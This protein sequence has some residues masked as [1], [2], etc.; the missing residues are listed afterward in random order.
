MLFQHYMYGYVPP[1]PK[2]VRA[3][4]LLEEGRHLAGMATRKRIALR[5]GPRHETVLVL[6]LVVPNRRAGRVPCLFGLDLAE[7]DYAPAS[8]ERGFA[9]ATFL[10]DEAAPDAPDFS[11]GAWSLFHRPGQARRGPHE[12]GALAV[13]AWGLGIAADHLAAEE[14]IDPARLA[15]V[16]HSRKAKA[17]ILAGALYESIGMVI[18][19]QSGT[20]GA[21][22]LRVHRGQGA[23][24]VADLVD[25]HLYWFADSFASFHDRPERLPFSQ[26]ALIALIA[27]RPILLGVAPDGRWTNPA[28][29]FRM[30]SLA[31]PAYRLL[32][33]E[34]DRP[35]ARPRKRGSLSVGRLGWY[36]RSH[37][38]HAMDV[39]DWQRSLDYAD[40]H[41]GHRP[42]LATTRGVLVP[43]ARSKPAPH[44]T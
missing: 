29:Q 10:K 22:P 15:V 9:F 30:L 24:T 4:V 3:E 39:D 43:A 31:E 13:W 36:V 35:D 18:A 17:A 34:G 8:V 14:A 2:D 6:V 23:E 1:L 37:N 28:G 19:H 40:A 7:A 26:A 11:R 16:G 38:G 21:A 44:G 27:P 41:F 5:F 20:G 32:G 12:W 25:E 42:S 33:V